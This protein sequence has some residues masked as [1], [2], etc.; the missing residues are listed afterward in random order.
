MSVV[1]RTRC[2][3]TSVIEFVTVIS[4]SEK[5]SQINTTFLSLTVLTTF[6]VLIFLY[7]VY[8]YLYIHL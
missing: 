1:C 3:L 7:Y 5:L 4:Y 6:N 2:L 8:V